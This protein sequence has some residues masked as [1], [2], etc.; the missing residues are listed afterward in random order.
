AAGAE[1]MERMEGLTV[2]GFVEVVKKI[3]AHLRLEKRIAKRLAR[4][5][6]KLIVLVDYPGFHLR[7]ARR[8]KQAGVPVLWYIAPQLW[9]W[10][11]SR[12]KKMARDVAHLAVILPFEEE[13]FGKHAVRSS[14]VGHPLLDRAP[15]EGD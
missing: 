11:E 13:Y 6:V 15:P 5:D 12:V 8:A 10:H 14:Y 9:A 3:P 2:L 4:G 7:V 1:L